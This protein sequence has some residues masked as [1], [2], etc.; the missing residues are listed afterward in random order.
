MTDAAVSAIPTN[1]YTGT[2]PTP[3]AIATAVWTDTTSGDLNVAGSP[4]KQDLAIPT[5]PYTGTP[6]TTVQ[7]AAAL[8]KTPANLLN[9]DSSGNVTANNSDFLSLS[10]QNNLSQAPAL[11][12]LA[13]SEAATAAEAAQ[14]LPTA[15]QIVAAIITAHRIRRT[16]A[17]RSRHIVEQWPNRTRYAIYRPGPGEGASR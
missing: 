7:I 16:P 1:P 15:A 5:N 4:G 9:T 2:P 12:A 6:P 8:L 3:A 17:N 10:E 11:A 14:A 13:A